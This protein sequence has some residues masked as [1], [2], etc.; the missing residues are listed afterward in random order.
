MRDAA[1]YRFRR[2]NMARQVM[3]NLRAEGKP[4]NWRMTWAAVQASV[5]IAGARRAWPDAGASK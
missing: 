1:T 4:R 3:V 2:R 5:K